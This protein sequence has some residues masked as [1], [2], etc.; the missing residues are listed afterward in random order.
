[1]GTQTNINVTL[2][3][4][5]TGL[6]EIVVVG[7]STQARKTLTGSVST[8]AADQLSENTS[9]SVAVRLQGNASGVSILNDHT[10][11]GGATIR[12]R[13][14]GT[15]NDNDPLWVVDGVPG[16]EVSP[17]DIETISILKDA[18][19]QAIYGA[20]AANG[21]VLVTTKTGSRNQAARV[22]INVRSG[23]SKNVNYFDLLNTEEYGEMLWLEA[24]NAGQVGYSHPQYGSGATPQ[25]S[26]YIRPAGANTVDESLYDDKLI[27]EDGDDTF[28]IMKAAIPGTEWLKEIDRTAKYREYTVDVTGGSA[29]TV[30]SFQG[31]YLLEEGIMKYT[32]YNRYN[33]RSNITTTP[34]KWIEIGEKVGITYSQDW[35]T[36]GDN[37]E[38]SPVAASYRM[39]PWVP[40]YDIRGGY[41]GSRAEGAG[42]GNNPMFTLDSNKDDVNTRVGL[43]GNVHV[44]ITPMEGLSFRTLMGIN[45]S[46]SNNKNYGFVER[47]DSER[48]TYASYS[49]SANFNLQ[50]SWTNTIEYGKTFAGVHDIKLILGSEAVN[51]N[52]NNFNGS[53]EDFFFEEIEYMTLGTGLISY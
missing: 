31:G 12:V 47:A 44:K 2:E 41:G 5:L 32:S 3:A 1:M 23:I 16:G 10:P 14:M 7:Y 45:W 50:W 38:G 4:Q 34:A 8:V 21:V 13:G 19:A 29:N 36:Q 24:A 28:L 11:G 6:D 53:R 52:S 35:G 39:P 37:S 30:Y 18:A 15:I 26:T 27:R 42:N 17:N 20:R 9:S 25:I 51:S 46:G 22:T 33:V 43:S 40:L 48:G 49:E